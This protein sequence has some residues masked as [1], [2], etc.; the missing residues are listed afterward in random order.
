[1]P[2]APGTREQPILAQP[3]DKVRERLTLRLQEGE[4]LLG[5]RVTSETELK[6]LRAETRQWD[7][8]NTELLRTLF[9]T[10][11]PG[12]EYAASHGFGVFGGPPSLQE[13]VESQERY[14]G[15]C[16]ERLQTILNCL[17]LYQEQ[18]PQQRGVP[19]PGPPGARRK[20]FVVHGHNDGAKQAVARFLER[21]GLE[22]VIL[23]EQANRGMTIIEKFEEHAVTVAFAVILLTADDLG[24]AKE[25][26]NP[27]PRARQNVIFEMGFFAAK[28]GRARVCAL[29]EP[30]I[31]S[32]SDYSGVVYIPLGPGEGWHLPLAK[33]LKAAGLDVDLNK[34]I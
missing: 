32:P 5:R 34:A 16:I 13:E 4:N 15:E 17:D 27:Q 20:V 22:I 14:I 31:E 28:L 1:M 9:A 33:E 26:Q 3:R 21:F 29:V 25:D 24:T 7:A 30:N 23:H 12:S 19:A 11:Q 10:E 6:K 8:Y 2:K 18:Q